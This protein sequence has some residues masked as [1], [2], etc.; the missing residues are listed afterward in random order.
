MD[1]LEA[2]I[3]GFIQGLTE[4][5]PISSTGHL[6]LGR[7]LLGLKDAGLFLDT[8]LHMG[9]LIA[10]LVFYKDILFSLLRRPF[11]KLTLLLFV[12]SIPA[13]IVGLLFADFFDSI[14]KS[15]VTIGWEFLVT[16]AMLWWADNMKNGA[17]RLADITVKDS[18]VIGC[19]QALAIFP[20]ISRSGLTIAGAL[21]CRV[22]KEAAAYFSFL[23]SIPVIFGAVSLQTAD[24][25]EGHASQISLHSLFFAT[26]SSAIFGYLAV[27][28][29]IQFVKRY[30]LKLF[31][32]YVWALGIII[33]FL[34]QT[35]S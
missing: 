25:L 28:W 8:M 4:F 12:G 31:A 1:L 34:Q 29:M 15:G 3:L 18:F 21:F 24:L 16:G 30:S 20:A 22:E 35:V 26:V 27:K 23:L 9:T 6:Y 7:V 32:I 5:L 14:S 19:F 11:S 2:I 17:K 13:I 33:I 10:L